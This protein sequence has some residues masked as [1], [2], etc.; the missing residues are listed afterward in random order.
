VTSDSKA[1]TQS[2]NE[3]DNINLNNKNIFFKYKQIKKNHIVL[4]KYFYI[5]S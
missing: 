2:R 3:E 1:P 5:F 4:Y